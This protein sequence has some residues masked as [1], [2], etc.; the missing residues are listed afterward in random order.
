M[1]NL[2]A[3]LEDKGNDDPKLRRMRI[4]GWKR[5]KKFVKKVVKVVKKAAPVIGAVIGG[6]IGIM[7]GN[8]ALAYELAATGY[9]IGSMV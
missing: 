7:S 3:I 2:Q 1:K 5:W 8:P 9:K 6:T 4:L